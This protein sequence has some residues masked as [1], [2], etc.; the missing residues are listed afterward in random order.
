M[1][2]GPKELL[3]QL[4]NLKLGELSAVDGQLGQ[5]SEALEALGQV[6]LQGR[7]DE[8]RRCLKAGK[9]RDFRKAL[10]TV[11]ARLGHLK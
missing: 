7:V 9:L 4:N 3:S 5:A 8:A 11:T 10:A 2:Q 6:E 1:A